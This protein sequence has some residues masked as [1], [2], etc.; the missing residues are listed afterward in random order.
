MNIKFENMED[1][2]DL[3]QRAHHH[4]LGSLTPEEQAMITDGLIQTNP[5]HRM[6]EWLDFLIMLD[7]LIRYPYLTDVVS[8]L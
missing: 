2:L 7:Y 3:F 4:G 6:M 5:H 8:R 1:H